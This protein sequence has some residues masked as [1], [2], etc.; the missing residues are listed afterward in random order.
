VVGGSRTLI[1]DLLVEFAELPAVGVAL[2]PSRAGEAASLKVDEE[3]MPCS[4]VRSPKRL[5]GESVG[6]PVA[7]RPSCRVVCP[8]KGSLVEVGVCLVV[9]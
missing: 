5:P 2:N 1:F 9:V 7:V 6:C 3:S 4:V 8:L